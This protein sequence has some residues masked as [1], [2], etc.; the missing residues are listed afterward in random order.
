[1]AAAQ[2]EV[3][4]MSTVRLEAVVTAVGTKEGSEQGI[5]LQPASLDKEE[6]YKMARRKDD[7]Y[8]CEK[9]DGE[10]FLLLLYRGLVLD[11]TH[12]LL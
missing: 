2:E 8:V 7:Y 4:T 1:M 3:G 12:V 11:V 9:T 5:S 10:R 6:M